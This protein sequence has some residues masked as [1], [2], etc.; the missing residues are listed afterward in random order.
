MMP[1]TTR[2][3]YAARIMVFLARHPGPEP[4]TKHEIGTSEGISPNYVEQIIIRLKASGLVRSH[5]G[6]SGGFTIGRSAESITLSDVLTAVEGPVTPAP[7]MTKGCPRIDICP[8]RP[9]WMRAARSLDSVF[10]STLL[11]ELAH[12][13]S[14]GATEY[15][16]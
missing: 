3:R 7:C 8:T 15:D 14:T 4:A 12:P 9:V 10:S 13:G 6:R 11:S 5:R 1:L 2:G 16:I